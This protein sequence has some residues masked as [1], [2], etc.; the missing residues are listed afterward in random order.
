MDGCYEARFMY[1]ISGRGTIMAKAAKSSWIRMDRFELGALM[2][3]CAGGKKM[4]GK[5][6]LDTREIAMVCSTVSTGLG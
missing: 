6:N 2:T 3:G 1:P 5:C 4:A